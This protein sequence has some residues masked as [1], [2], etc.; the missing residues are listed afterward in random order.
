M[1]YPRRD[2]VSCWF[3]RTAVA[4]SVAVIGPQEMLGLAWAGTLRVDTAPPMML[5]ATAMD[6]RT[7]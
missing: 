5:T 3:S 4:L 1:R 2:P 6:A 7:W